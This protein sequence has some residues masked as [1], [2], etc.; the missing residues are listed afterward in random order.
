MAS[1]NEVQFDAEDE[2][3]GGFDVIPAGEYAAQ[4]IASEMKETKAGTGMYLEMRVQLLEPPYQGRLVFERLNLVN[5]NEV[6]VKIAKRSF[7]ELCEALGTSP[8]EVE[9][10][11]ELHGQEFIAV[12][13]VDPAR[14]DWGESNSVRKYKAS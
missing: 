5:P 6:A 10:S 3:A 14:G 4:I 7:R 13:K 2:D 8:E 9:D 1:L 11:E 12:L